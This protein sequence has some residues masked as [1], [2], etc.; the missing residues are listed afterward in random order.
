M[1]KRHR[2]LWL[3]PSNFFLLPSS[4][5]MYKCGKYLIIPWWS[6]AACSFCPDHSQTPSNTHS[7]VCW[8]ASRVLI[9]V[10][11][12]AAFS[13]PNGGDRD[14]TLLIHN[15]L[16]LPIF[17]RDT[18][19]KNYRII[20]GKTWLLEDLWSKPLLTAE[21]TL[22]LQGSGPCSVE[23][24]RL[25]SEFC[26]ADHILLE[27]FLPHVQNQFPFNIILTHLFPSLYHD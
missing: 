25:L 3:Q 24:N 17:M 6:R 10:I 15:S 9:D 26:L 4:A 11:W 19:I 22:T 14:F 12:A 8:V 13:I 20:F 5:A 2:L 18:G 27:L 16:P 7:Q 21:P 1:P 23:G